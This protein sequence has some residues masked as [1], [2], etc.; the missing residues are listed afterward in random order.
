MKYILFFLIISLVVNCSD[1]KELPKQNYSIA[2][3]INGIKDSVKAVFYN[4]ETLQ[5]ID[6]TYVI[7]NKFK[8]R[9]FI[10]EPSSGLIYFTNST[11]EK[12]PTILFWID[13]TNINI[14]AN[15]KSLNVKD[16]ATCFLRKSQISGSK[17]NHLVIDYKEQVDSL[18]L[19]RKIAINNSK[20]EQEK[21]LISKKYKL[22]QEKN[23]SLFVFNNYNN[24]FSI[25]KIYDERNFRPKPFINRYYHLLNDFY[26]KS[27]KGRLIFNFLQSNI[28]KEGDS[29]KDF[30]GMTLNN[31]KISLSN[32]KN[33]VVLLDF[34]TS[35]CPPCRKQIREEFPILLEKF[36]KEEFEIVSFSLD[37]N[38][39]LW[40]KASYEDKI[41]W[42]N[43]SDLKGFYSSI[44]I[45][46]GIQLIPRTFIIDKSG[47]VNKSF[48]GYNKG[49]IEKELTNIFSREE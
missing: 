26:K 21:E 16:N 2:V 40:K 47:I 12:Y 13:T 25:K 38:Y 9:G 5:P 4:M 36:K 1:E 41:N 31:K 22:L 15:L 45:D 37:S 34:W 32:F 28:I 39:E 6:S 29:L 11:I 23:D 17:L 18:I 7:D 19:N 24:Y 49:L 10:D 14:V 33:K 20:T 3:N 44:V 35:N 46:Y 27:S 8:F 48:T 43:I 30:S 42:I